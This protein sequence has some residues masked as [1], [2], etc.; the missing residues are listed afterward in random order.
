VC[1]AKVGTSIAISSCVRYVYLFIG[2]ECEEIPSGCAGVCAGAWCAGVCAGVCGESARACVC[3]PAYVKWQI[4]APRD[5]Y[6][7][8]EGSSV[9]LFCY[10]W[11]SFGLF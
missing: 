5:V 6:T 4:E 9:G 3:A 11:G 2:I 8:Q 10:C 7:H 1:L